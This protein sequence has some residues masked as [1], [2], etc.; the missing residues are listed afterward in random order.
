VDWKGIVQGRQL[1]FWGYKAFVKYAQSISFASCDWSLV[2][3]CYIY[4][5]IAFSILCT[6]ISGLVKAEKN[7]KLFPY[8]EHLCALL[9]CKYVSWTTIVARS[10]DE[11]ECGGG[12]QSNSSK[13]HLLDDDGAVLVTKTKPKQ[14]FRSTWNAFNK[15]LQNFKTY[16]FNRIF[17]LTN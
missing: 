3:H 11:E 14:A 6:C 1:V 5:Y 16:L 10:R 15:L 12:P 13:N 8:G 4:V 7:F 17:W 2:T 9:W